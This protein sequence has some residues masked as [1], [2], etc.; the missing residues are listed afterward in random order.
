MKQQLTGM[1]AA[2][3]LREANLQVGKEGA[4]HSDCIAL[5]DCERKTVGLEQRHVCAE[6]CLHVRIEAQ[7]VVAGRVRGVGT[8]FKRLQ[9]VGPSASNADAQL[10]FYQIAQ[11]AA[12]RSAADLS[13]A[14]WSLGVGFNV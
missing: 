11:W 7:V 3:S 5:L 8:R 10:D 14:L 4:R 12:Q 2:C 1:I 13:V 6:E 9:G